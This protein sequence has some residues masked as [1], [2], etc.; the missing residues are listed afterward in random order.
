MNLK[1]LF[2][3]VFLSLYSCNIINTNNSESNDLSESINNN[4]SSDNSS[5]SNND[6]KDRDYYK[7]LVD[8][9]KINYSPDFIND[10]S[11]DISTIQVF[12]IN[13]THGAFHDESGL[14]GIGRVATCINEKTI[15]PYGVVKIANG[16]ILQGTAFSNMLIGEP[17]IAALNEMNF[18]CFVIGNHEFDWGLDLL[19]AY[20][21]GNLLN[22]EL[23]CP[24]LGANIIDATGKMPEWIQPYTIVEK[25]DVKVGIIGV[26]GENLESSISH[27]ALAGYQFTSSVDAVNKY[28]KIL[29][30]EEKVDVLIVSDHNHDKSTNQKYVNTYDVDLII[31]GHD[32]NKITEYVNRYDSMS[33]P[34]VES[35][36][37]NKS[38][39]MV[40]LNLDSNNKVVSNSVTHF[41]PGNFTEDSNLK[42]IMDLYYEVTSSYQNEI[43]G[44]TNSTLSKSA[45]AGSVCTY[46]ADK[47]QADIAF[48]NT[49]G[50][51]ASIGAG[52]ITISD[53]YEVFP[54][55][56]EIVYAY[57]TGAEIKSMIGNNISYYY[58]N[59]GFYSNSS[60][61]SVSDLISNEK[62]KVLT[63]DFMLGKTYISKYMNE[64][65]NLSYTGDYIRDCAI[66]D[67]KTNYKK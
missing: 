61:L 18:D 65:H 51:R 46:M 7:T 39:A 56:N 35:Y 50:V 49:G 28:A 36:T 21:D 66:E 38:M 44:H 13:D 12:E 31:N 26:L 57:L 67:I 25:G 5:T 48:V 4:I 29:L 33:I 54:F 30:E 1:F 20:K 17:G 9:S 15:D 14:V 34:V 52:N 8:R 41:T 37:K 6:Y 62:Y 19:S 59:N 40:T 22:G 63:I 16:D 11:K 32:H 2:I 42:N 43:I 47:Y 55:D 10:N 58:Y 45:F 3:T 60:S 27:I 23:E 24:F 64:S 53:V